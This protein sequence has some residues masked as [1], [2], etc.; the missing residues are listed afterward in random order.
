MQTLDH[1]S[2]SINDVTSSFAQLAKLVN[3]FTA[4]QQSTI[5][6]MNEQPQQQQQHQASTNM[7]TSV[8]MQSPSQNNK[9][10]AVLRKL[11]GEKKYASA[12]E[13]TCDQAI[14]ATTSSS[15]MSLC[16]CVYVSVF[17]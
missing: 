15:C 3:P 12:L 2:S 13:L 4:A 8:A 6:S 9:P 5:N 16:G 14:A 7:T 11:L 1:V 10:P 17:V